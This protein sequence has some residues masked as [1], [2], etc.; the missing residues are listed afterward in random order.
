MDYYNHVTYSV[1]CPEECTASQENETTAD[2]KKEE[3][4]EKHPKD[5]KKKLVRFR[6]KSVEESEHCRLNV[7]EQEH[8][9]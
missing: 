3:K 1:C 4:H 9:W 5:E 7:D 6:L 2:A 8:P